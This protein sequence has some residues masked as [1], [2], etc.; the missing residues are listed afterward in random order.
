MFVDAMLFDRVPGFLLF[1]YSFCFVF[2]C[3]CCFVFFFFCVYLFFFFSS[4]RRHTRSWCDWSSDVCL[5]ISA[6]L[7]GME[8]RKISSRELIFP[9]FTRR[10]SLVTGVHPASSRP[11]PRPRPR[12]LPRPRDRESVVQGKSVDLGG[13]RIIQ[14]QY[15]NISLTLHYDII[16]SNHI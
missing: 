5:P 2:F 16:L 13:R 11:P 7:T 12:P 14:K 4:R 9:S 15:Y 6:S 3:F 8:K 1:A 10:P